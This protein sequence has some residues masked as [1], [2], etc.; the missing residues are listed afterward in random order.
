MLAISAPILETPVLLLGAALLWGWLLACQYAFVRASDRAFETLDVT[1]EIA[2]STV[3]TDEETEVTVD[4]RVDRY[5][6][7]DLSLTTLISV[8]ATDLSPDARTLSLPNGEVAT[9]EFLVEW[10][11]A[12]TFEV[13]PVEATVADR[14]GLFGRRFTVDAVESVSV[15]PRRPR[16]VHVGEGTNQVS[17]VTGEHDT[18]RPGG[19]MELLEIR[20]YVPGDEVQEIDWKATARL[21]EVHIREFEGKTSRTTLVVFDH[22]SRLDI[23]PPGAT[24]L[25]YLRHVGLAFVDGTAE[26]NDPIGF[27]GVV[28]AERQSCSHR[29]RTTE[30]TSA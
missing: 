12:G 17:L 22:R 15:V 25:E 20:E 6:E 30:R 7:V 13:G 4:A 2:D 23:G 24:E 8:G 14:Y 27:V 3:L 10:P 29:V 28:T 19:G 18:D 9:T 21:R 1:V 11:I 26:F 16:N 5:P